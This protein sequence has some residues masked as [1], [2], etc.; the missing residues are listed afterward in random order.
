MRRMTKVTM[1]NGGHIIALRDW[2]PLQL[3]SGE[4]WARERIFIPQVRKQKS[5]LEGHSLAFHTFPPTFLQKGCFLLVAHKA[6]LQTAEGRPTIYE[7]KMK[8]QKQKQKKTV[9]SPW[10]ALT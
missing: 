7:K 5:C 6:G 9:H 10:M 8:K 1:L 4:K 3:I 2:R